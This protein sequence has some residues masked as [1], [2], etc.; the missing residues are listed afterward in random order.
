MTVLLGASSFTVAPE[1]A[2]AVGAS[3]TFATGNENGVSEK[4]PP[5]SLARTVTVAVVAVS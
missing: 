4:S 2:R 3:L 1:S 5:G